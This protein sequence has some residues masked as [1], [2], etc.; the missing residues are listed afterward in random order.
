MKNRRTFID[1]NITE[2]LSLNTGGGLGATQ[3]PGL[4]LAYK[5]NDALKIGVAGRVEDTDFRLNNSGP[6]PGG[7][8]EERSVPVVATI[9]WTPNPAISVSAFAGMEFNGRLTLKDANNNRIDQR[10]FDRAPIVGA[11]AGFRF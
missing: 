9:D 11:T 3:G 1:W 2:K 8:G 4:N 5:F 6:A 10:E 7:I